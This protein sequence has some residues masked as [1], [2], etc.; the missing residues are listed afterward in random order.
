[1]KIAILTLY[2]QHNYGGI[3][4]AY[5]LQTVLER[6]GNS[7]T[8]IVQEH[9]NAMKSW[10]APLFLGKRILRNVLGKKTP[11]FIEWKIQKEAPIM[12]KHTIGFVNQ[13]IHL[14]PYKNF[15]SINENDFDA[16]IVGSDQVWR[17][18]YLHN[19]PEEAFLNFTDGWNI[20]RLAYA[21]SFGV[22][23][24]EY[25]SKQTR[26][27]SRLA[28]KFDGIAVREDS[29]VTLCHKYL[30]VDAK[31][32]IDPT[33]LLT[34]E[35]YLNLVKKHKTH[36]IEGDLMTYILDDTDKKE[37]LV[38]RVAHEKGLKPFLAR[39]KSS[40]MASSIENRIQPPVEQW[41]R[42]FIDSK[43]VIT[44]SFH[45]TVFSII[46]RKQF[47]AVGNKQ[48]GMSRFISLLNM[49]NLQD[50]LVNVDDCHIP[51]TEI[52]YDKVYTIL[53]RLKGDALEF[54]YK[55]LNR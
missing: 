51:Q 16:F 18:T 4:Q 49:F 27:C 1:M 26:E 25:S 50:R 24:W 44:D 45:G 10:K 6:M 11:L 32:V 8:V 2:P 47:I 3:L 20:I 42:S 31:N 46:F 33:M 21:A 23:A 28:K 35:D 39:S 36:V 53:N 17:P 22:D 37:K 40:D 5:A 9:K 38:E 43:F 14:C 15:K 19:K 7:V 12:W 30:G 13:Y 55:G 34:V 41:L 48:R 29:G 52:D 54:L